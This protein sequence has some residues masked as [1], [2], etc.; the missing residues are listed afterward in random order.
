MSPRTIETPSASRGLGS[1]VARI[2]PRTGSP[3]ST[4]RR[5]MLY[6][7]CPLAP[8]TSVGLSMVASFP[9]RSFGSLPGCFVRRAFSGNFLRRRAPVGAFEAVPH[10][11]Q[12]R[13]QRLLVALAEHLKHA[14]SDRFHPSRVLAQRHRPRGGGLELDR[15]AVTAVAHAP[16]QSFLLHAVDQARHRAHG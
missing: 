6:P 15:S 8:V 13:D 3:R 9:F 11:A 16:H 4:R 2:I 7:R 10:A 12:N 5:Q 14:A 1:A